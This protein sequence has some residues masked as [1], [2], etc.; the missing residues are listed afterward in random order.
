MPLEWALRLSDQ[1]LLLLQIG[2]S[3]LK[4]VAEAYRKLRGTL[5]FLL[6]NLADFDPESNAVSYDQLPAVDQWLLARHAQVMSEVR[7]AYETYQVSYKP[8]SILLAGIPSSSPC[9]PF[10]QAPAAGLIPCTGLSGT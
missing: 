7:D 5:R 6:G 8:I 2:Q 10:A 3:I 9:L 4:Q 1:G